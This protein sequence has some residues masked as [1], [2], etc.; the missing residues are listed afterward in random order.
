MIYCFW[1]G[2]N[3]MSE[4]RKNG[5]KEI[6]SVSGCEVNLITI[7]NLSDYVKYPFH[8][9][10]EYLTLTHRSDY[11]RSYFMHYY[12]G[13]YSD[14]KPGLHSWKKTFKALK[15]N[16]IVGYKE[17]GLW[18]VAGCE[19][20]PGVREQLQESW[21]S[22]IGCSSFICLPGT[23]FTKEWL[24]EVNG[25]LTSTYDLLKKHPGGSDDYPL[26]WTELMGDIFHP[27]VLKYKDYVLQ[28]D[29][30]KPDFTKEY[31]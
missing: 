31:R 1:T 5:L 25:L 16:Y 10:Y 2:K 22:L 27:L 17:V 7:N 12:G 19:N 3:E 4:N 14:I 8:P 13:G 15:N 29:S 30:I 24:K 28:D 26:T 20:K 9:A 11:L 21:E 23:P 6:K 18:A